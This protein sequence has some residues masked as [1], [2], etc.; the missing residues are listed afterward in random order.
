MKIS[1][2]MKFILLII[3]VVASA[4]CGYFLGL[5]RPLPS[6][7]SME[8]SFRKNK[9]DFMELVRIFNEDTNL[10]RI[11]YHWT[12]V[13]GVSQSSNETGDPGISEERWNEYRTLFRKLNLDGG[14]NRDPFDG[15]M[16]FFAFSKGLAVNGT[17]KG[18]YYSIKPIPCKVAQH[19]DLNKFEDGVYCKSIDE[20]WYMYISR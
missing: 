14:I 16:M 6:D 5:S 9:Q 12:H 18:Y 15:T 10:R 17:L 20:N 13:V 11:D 19:D 2:R 8:E 3:A 7:A 1:S 4:N